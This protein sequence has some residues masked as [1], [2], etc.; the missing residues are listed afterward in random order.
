MKFV[1]ITCPLQYP[2]FLLQKPLTLKS[3]RKNRP[4]LKVKRLSKT[5]VKQIS[6]PESYLHFTID[7]TVSRKKKSQF[8]YNARCLLRNVYFL[9]IGEH[10][11]RGFRQ[12]KMLLIKSALAGILNHLTLQA[13][14]K[15]T[16]RP[17]PHENFL[18][19]K[20][21]VSFHM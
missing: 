1:I 14:F 21:Q 15:T 10:C 5:L 12:T 16:T 6:L 18:C 7:E 13:K 8:Q 11:Y 17:I 20:F 3:H 19:L 4:T 9:H 2:Q